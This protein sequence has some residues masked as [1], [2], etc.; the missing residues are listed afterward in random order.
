MIW[1]T[2]S[3]QKKACTLFSSSREAS[4]WPSELLPPSSAGQPVRGLTHTVQLPPQALLLH[5]RVG[6]KGSLPYPPFVVLSIPLPL[7]RLT[8]KVNTPAHPEAP[9]DV[10]PP[11]PSTF[12]RKR[13]S[14]LEEKAQIQLS[15]C[16][17][18]HPFC[19]FH[20]YALT[21]AIYHVNSPV[22]SHLRTL[23]MLASGRPGNEP[24]H[25]SA[26]WTGQAQRWACRAFRVGS[27][28]VAS[29]TEMESC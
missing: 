20:S 2:S 8:L 5:A 7:G 14:G 19:I 17:L 18:S 22:L 21:E 6:E 26:G 27:P 29:N 28:R 3:G 16:F 4:L 13:V 1:D 9:D 25:S 23:L 12:I 10:T 15:P 11:D 24:L